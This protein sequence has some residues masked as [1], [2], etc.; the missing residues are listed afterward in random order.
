[1]LTNALSPQPGGYSMGDGLTEQNEHTDLTPAALPVK[2]AEQP[3]AIDLYKFAIWALAGIGAVG[4]LG[5]I[6][7]PAMGRTV[8][9][10]VQTVVA[11]AVTALAGMVAGEV[12]NG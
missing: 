7:V 2:I 12:R 3:G 6:I 1:M 10:G 9:D 5:M 4:V 11:I 8:G